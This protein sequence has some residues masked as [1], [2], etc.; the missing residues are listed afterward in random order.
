MLMDSL[1]L[2]LLAF[3]TL[4]FQLLGFPLLLFFLRQQTPQPE[5]WG[6]GRIVGWLTAGLTIWGIA[7][8]GVPLN[9][10][11]GLAIVLV[12]L[13]I[14]EWRFLLPL[15]QP[16]LRQ[17][18]RENSWNII[19]QEILFLS[20]FLFLSLVR[21]YN[22]AVL[23]L[24]KFMNAG[25]LQGYLRSP[26]LP[27]MDFWLAGQTINYYSFGH[28]LGSI[29]LRFWQV[30]VEVGFN[31]LL[32][33]MMGLVLM[34]AYSLGCTLLRP[35]L[36]SARSNRRPLMLAGITGA[37]LIVFGGNSHPI[38]YGLKHLGFQKYWFA[39]AARFIEFTIHEFPAYSFIVSDLHAHFWS[40]PIVLLTLFAA[41]WWF[42]MV[43]TIHISS[44]A[45]LFASRQVIGHSVVLGALLGVLGMA[46]TWDMIVYS[47]F[48]GIIGCV[49]AARSPRRLWVLAASAVWTAAAALIVIGPWLFYFSS[50]ING[51]FW[52]QERSPL[53]QLAVLWTGHVFFSLTA[54]MT[55][56]LFLRK[57]LDR[58]VSG[59]FVIGLGITA[60]FFVLLPEVIYFKDIYPTFPRANTMF[61]F[62]FQAFI[63]MSLLVGWLFGFL[64]RSPSFFS[65]YARK[66]WLML[67][68]LFVAG[69]LAFSFKGYPSYYR[70]FQRQSNLD[71]LTWLR[72][73]EP[74]EYE[75]IL[76]LR[77]YTEDRPVVVEAVGDSYSKFGRV[78]VFSGLPTVL[79]WRAHEWLWRGGYEIPRQRTEEVRTIYES[80]RSAAALSILKKYAVQFIFIGEQE[81]ETYTLDTAGLINLGSIVFQ[82]GNVLIIKIRI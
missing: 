62:T 47:V 40:I 67:I 20:G 4:W 60:W 1:F 6:W 49:A 78:S 7:H 45:Q 3:S 79:G 13:G 41:W 29:L 38:W 56:G 8:V 35:F 66:V 30:P 11:I 27:A 59:I 81:R 14:A 54:V 76:W 77:R 68:L 2:I 28:F 5:W 12:I 71:G 18:I 65:K 16:Q 39:E 80:P 17:F 37:L 69:A 55:A 36:P 19:F 34:Q 73:A 31:V 75:G 42:Q 15:I 64:Q 58:F 53:W 23:D 24:E 22:P 46:N 44:P 26:T 72:S 43:D 25:L 21:T 50:I 9:T 48:L 70:N 61:K 52:V 63:L 32:G 74:E 10:A 57:H 33:W 82:R 51:I